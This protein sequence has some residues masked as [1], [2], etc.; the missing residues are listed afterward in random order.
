MVSRT[1]AT[2]ACEKGG[3]WERALEPTQ[4]ELNAPRLRHGHQRVHEGWPVGAS[5]GARALELNVISYIH[6]G[7]RCA[8]EGRPEGASVVRGSAVVSL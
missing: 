4:F 3:Q 8:R 1:M 2:S 6:Y 7:H 5:V